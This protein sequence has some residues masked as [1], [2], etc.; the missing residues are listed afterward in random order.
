MVLSGDR[1]ASINNTFE[2]I[3]LF[4]YFDEFFCCFSAQTIPPR[5][6]DKVH[7]VKMGELDSYCDDAKV[8]KMFLWPSCQLRDLS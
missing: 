2:L 1:Y 3:V 5:L 6:V 7:N 8:F 4:A